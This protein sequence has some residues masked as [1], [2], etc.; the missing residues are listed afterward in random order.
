MSTGLQVERLND[1][2]KYVKCAYKQGKCE[3]VHGKS[4]EG[5]S[6]SRTMCGFKEGE[7]TLLSFPND[8]KCV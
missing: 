8:V 1:E 2:E 6:I 4:L 5:I 3:Q 7:R